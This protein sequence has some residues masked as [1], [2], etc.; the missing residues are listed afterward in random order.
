MLDDAAVRTER[1]H[2]ARLV[3]EP[4][5]FP[6]VE[7]WRRSSDVK[8][9]SCARRA[10]S[11]EYIGM[12]QPVPVDSQAAATKAKSNLT[13]SNYSSLNDSSHSPRLDCSDTRGNAVRHVP[14]SD[15]SVT[16]RVTYRYDQTGRA[17]G[18]MI[19]SVKCHVRRK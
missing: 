2:V 17:R 19:L 9:N 3:E 7:E 6:F 4:D 12:R 5:A 16:G 1:R 8:I 18:T 10:G 14:R 15:P 11:A 13:H